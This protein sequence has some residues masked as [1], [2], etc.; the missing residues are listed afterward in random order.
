MISLVREP[1]LVKPLIE[2]GG[3]P[4]SVACRPMALLGG[5]DSTGDDVV[6]VH[7]RARHGCNGCRRCRQAARQ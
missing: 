7:Q 1:P 3:F 6:A 2:A 5:N 4:R